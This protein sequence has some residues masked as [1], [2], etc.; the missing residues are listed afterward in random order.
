MYLYNNNKAKLFDHKN[1]KVIKFNHKIEF[2]KNIYEFISSGKLT[3]NDEL[4]VDHIIV[5]KIVENKYLIQCFPT[6]ENKKSNL[7]LTVKLKPCNTD[8]IRF[9]FLD[10]S[11]NIHKNLIASLKEKLDGNYNFIIESYKTDYKNG[12]KI[13]NAIKKIEKVNFKILLND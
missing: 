13:N 12:F 4:Y 5:E 2:K 11:N 6:R 1:G 10:L 8:L 3:P 9:Y 7:E